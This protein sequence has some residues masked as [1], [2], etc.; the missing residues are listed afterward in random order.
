MPENM[1]DT[2]LM[3]ADKHNVANHATGIYWYP[4]SKQI[5]S[6]TTA[7]A[8]TKQQSVPTQTSNF[9]HAKNPSCQN[10]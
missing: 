3:I 5:A 2:I 6:N 9:A 7:Q 4:Q 8:K 10:N 1:L